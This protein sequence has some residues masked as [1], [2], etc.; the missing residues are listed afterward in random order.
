VSRRNLDGLRVAITGATSG[1]GR[2]IAVELASRGSKLI[3]NGRR[4]ER[5]QELKTEIES[6][7]GQCRVV[8]GDITEPATRVQIIEACRNQWQAVD[9]L[10]N[11]AGIGAMGRFDEASEQRLRQIFEVNFFSAVELI[12]SALPLL[13]AGRQPIIV[14][15][16]SVLGHRAVPFKSEYCA[17]KF[18]I[19][20]FSDAL[21]GELQEPKIDVLLISPST[22]DSEFFDSAIED[23][24]QRDWKGARAMP[25]ERVA[26]VAA[27][28]IRLGRK[29]VIISMGG[30]ALVWLDRLAPSFADY[31]IAKFAK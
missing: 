2:A 15:V 21:R 8:A 25:P 12:R 6:S 18:A 24:M 26:V 22:T 30:K 5:L 20:G 19:H 17:S 27:H 11:C 1:I 13:S 10:I 9:C 29:E 28:A 31:L 16:S 23:R 3:V 14:N 4:A 7:G